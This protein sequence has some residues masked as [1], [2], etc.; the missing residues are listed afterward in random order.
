MSF[1]SPL[2]ASFRCRLAILFYNFENVVLRVRAGLPK[3]VMQEQFFNFMG[4]RE[5]PFHVS[6]DPRFYYS[7]PAHESAL[8]DLLYGIETRQGFMVLT[9]E[10]GT[11]KTTL[12]NQILAYLRQRRRSSAYIFHAHLKPMGLLRFILSD[13]GLPC[14]SR[15]KSVLVRNLHSWLLERHAVRDRPVI[16]L[17]EAQSLPLQTLDELRL[18]LNLET[19][20]GKLLQ[21]ILSGQPELEE[22][23][24]LPALRQ[25]RQRIMFHSR[26]PVLTQKETADYISSRLAAAGC[27]DSSLFPDEAVENIYESSRGIPRVVNL[28]CEHA[29]I[30]AYAE[31]QRVVSP[32]IV[33]RIAVDFELLTRPLAVND[34]ELRPQGERFAQFPVVEKPA[35]SFGAK[36]RVTSC[37]WKQIEFDLFKDAPAAAGNGARPA[38]SENA[39]PGVSS[40]GPPESPAPLAQPDFPS[41]PGWPSEAI[42]HRRRHR[43]RS[44]IAMFVRNSAASVERVWQAATSS[45]VSYARYARLALFSVIQKSAPSSVANHPAAKKDA[46]PVVTNPAPV[47]SPKHWQRHP[48]RSAVA[49]F[50]RNS[51]ASV[52]RVWQAATSSFVSYARY[53]RL[54]WF[55]VIQKLLPPSVANH[56]AAKKDAVPVVT[57]PAPVESPKHWQRHPSLSGVVILARNSAASVGRAWR[58]FVHRLAPAPSLKS[59]KPVARP[60]APSAPA[61]S[62]GIVK[63][64]GRRRSLSAVAINARNSAASVRRAWHAFTQP[65]LCYAHDVS[66]SFVRD[67]RRWFRSI[68]PPTPVLDFGSS[69]NSASE[70][71]AM[72]QNLL[73]PI[74]HWL[75]R[76]MNRGQISSHRSQARSAYRK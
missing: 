46:V 34:P 75:R 8:T 63:S 47:E 3:N 42:Y 26:L 20:Q 39:V 19:P 76:P 24:R 30:S 51:A 50:A 53:T 43:S 67:C 31:Q 55:S 69:S 68:T 60:D 4:L 25:L 57:D 62:N 35:P 2:L 40:P 27:S 36:Q 64:Q 44:A 54:A 65:L 29:L 17:D 74:V 37:P 66:H 33:Q 10:A 28:I 22:K 41:M 6:P 23:L 32:E 14:P 70:K 73:A 21:I 59:P 48:S 13:F 72:H 58:V 61:W 38:V 1:W 11:G 9:G 56:P 45:F 52:G 12:L 49:M 71:S 7:S 16:I 15:S 5:D 18:L